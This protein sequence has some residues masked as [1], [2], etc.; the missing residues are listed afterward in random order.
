MTVP[1][2]IFCSASV[3]ANLRLF[4][5]VILTLL[6]NIHLRVIIISSETWHSVRFIVSGCSWSGHT[7]E[8]HSRPKLQYSQRRSQYSKPRLQYYQS[9]D[10]DSNS[11]FSILWRRRWWIDQC[12]DVCL[13]QHSEVDAAW[14]SI[15]F[16]RIILSR[17]SLR[18]MRMF[19]FVL[20]L[21]VNALFLIFFA[22]RC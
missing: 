14:V 9:V 22:S 21:L 19:T 4:S 13:M 8:S 5:E 20:C 7:T 10:S 11:Q 18:P 6:M 3:Y 1:Y 15:L 16:I 2:R 17:Q 12:W